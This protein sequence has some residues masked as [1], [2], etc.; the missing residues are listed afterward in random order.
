MKERKS[1]RALIIN[2]KNEVLLEK[3]EFPKVKGNKVL[4]VTPGG[5]LKDDETYEIALE[6]ELYEELGLEV[7]INSNPVLV[8]DVLIEGK[9]EMFN[10]HE[11]YYLLNLNSNQVFN[12][13]NMTKNEIDTLQG[14]KWW[15]LQELKEI[16][17]FAP[18]EI[19]E[20]LEKNSK[21]AQSEN[22]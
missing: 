11:V 8:K 15:T 7:T 9:I 20:I 16:A 3:F 4:W 19:K 2:E 21:L 18:P 10:S 5:G 1:A 17:N 12:L 13:K 22:V 6:R 14:I